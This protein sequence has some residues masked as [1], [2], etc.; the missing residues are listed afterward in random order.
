MNENENIYDE[1]RNQAI[2]QKDDSLKRLEN[3]FWN[4]IELQ[5]YKKAIY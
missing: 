2:L 5:E 1:E 4:H 3:S